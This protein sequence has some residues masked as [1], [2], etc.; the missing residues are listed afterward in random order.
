MEMTV[1]L[2]ASVALPPGKEPTLSTG[3]GA[4]WAPE[5]VWMR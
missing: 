1:Q 5:P 2:H 4:G 3:Q